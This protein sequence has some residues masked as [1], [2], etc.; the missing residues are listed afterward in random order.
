MTIGV[1][2]HQAQ[3]FE[4]C[5]V[6]ASDDEMVVDRNADGVAGLND[7]KRHIYISLAWRRVPAGVIMRKDDC[8]GFQSQPAFDNFAR[9]D[10]RAVYRA[11]AE[12]FIFNE[13]VLAVQK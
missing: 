6:F 12:H 1:K 13:A 9:I 5:Y 10:R 7:L 8:C 2:S 4:T 3:H 11:F